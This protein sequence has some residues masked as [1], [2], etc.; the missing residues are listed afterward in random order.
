MGYYQDVDEARFGGYDDSEQIRDAEFNKMTERF[1]RA[2]RAET[3]ATIECACCGRL[4]VKKTYQQKFCP[5]VK[6]KKKSY[7][8]KDRYNNTVNP[9]GKFEH[10]HPRNRE[11]DW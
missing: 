8:C 4:I 6:G 5:V 11:D 1:A 10:L 3:G 9:R 2:T 7:R